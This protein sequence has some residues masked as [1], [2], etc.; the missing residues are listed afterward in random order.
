MAFIFKKTEIPGI[1]LIQT[2][3]YKDDRGFFMETYKS[4]IFKENGIN[5]EFL[6]D[7]QSHSKKDVLRGLHYQ[8]GAFAQGKLVQCV[9]GEIFDVAADIRPRSPTFGKWVS[10]ILSDKN[11]DQLY[12][13]AGFAHG[14]CVVSEEAD[15]IY[16]MTQ[17]YSPGN[18]R[19]ILWN[20]PTL[21]IS[22]PISS[23]ILSIK[24]SNNPKL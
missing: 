5:E 8:T 1:I 19:G 12:I 21:N 10:A 13:P 3:I 7:S 11:H 18:E 17:E 23:P 15:I 2:D 9:W 22:W 16:R 14:F 4:S 20:D 24:D 6:Q